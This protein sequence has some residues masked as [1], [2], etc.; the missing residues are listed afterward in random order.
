MGWT[1]TVFVWIIHLQRRE[2]DNDV[3]PTIHRPELI[4]RPAELEG[5]L[6]LADLPHEKEGRAGWG[7]GGGEGRGGGNL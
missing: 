7:V 1:K 3:E 6:V 2:Y 5:I 4:P